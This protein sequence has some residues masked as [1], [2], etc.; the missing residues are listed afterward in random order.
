M[1]LLFPGRHQLLTNFQFEYLHSIINNVSK[2]SDINGQPLKL[3]ATV[4]AVIFAVT[5]ANHSNTRRNPLPFYLRALAI[6]EFAR[7]FNV[8]VYV[9]GIDD[10]GNLPN[11]AS[12]TLKTVK[13]ESEGLFN[14]SPSNTAVVCSTPVLTMYEKLGFAILPA[15]LSDRKAWTYQHQ[16]PWDLVEKIANDPE[17][18]SKAEIVRDIHVSSRELWEK[19][20]LDHKVRLL[21]K[22]TMIGDDGDITTTRDY[23]TYVR[24]M[25]EIAE[26]KYRETA[27][28][29]RPGRIG[30][31]GCAV[32]SWIKLACNDERYRESDFYGIEVARHLYDI[33]YQRKHNGEFAN[34]FVFFLQRNAVTGLV[35]DA[36]SMNTIHTSSLTHEIESYGSRNELLQFIRNRYQELANGGIWINR[37]VVGP[38]DKEKIVLMKLTTADGRND[39]YDKVHTGRK[40]LR[41]YLAGLSTYGRFLRF[42]QDF[43]KKEGYTLKHK[44]LEREGEYYIQL[45]LQDAC[46][47]MSR[48][49]YIDNWQSEM[50][51][52]FCFWDFDE[53]K[54]HLEQAGFTIAPESKA[55]TNPWIVENRLRGKL[56]LFEQTENGLWQIEYPVTNMI[57][58]GEKR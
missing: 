21:F 58:L 6:Q 29:V 25:D 37:D 48:K 9:Y 52:T 28:H 13:H 47:F 11:F 5:S 34:P 38:S 1:Y 24:Q 16:L 33:C 43:R 15:E 12:Y 36:N 54:Q 56:E 30:D 18:G 27:S 31:I 39:D 14:L 40:E 32:G 35:F 44:I 51:E 20:R 2:S 53:W 41:D 23:N 22:D 17:W 42:A 4:Q 46:E 26:L 49:D 55:Y 7:E 50:H 3:D 8:P 45:T 10:V 19:Y 57:L